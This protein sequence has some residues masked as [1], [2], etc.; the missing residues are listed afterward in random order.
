[1]DEKELIVEILM[2]MLRGAAKEGAGI[3]ARLVNEEQ[4]IAL[5]ETGKVLYGKNENG[6]GFYQL[7]EIEEVETA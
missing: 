3:N 2:A 5:L 4:H 7:I 1:M 6:D